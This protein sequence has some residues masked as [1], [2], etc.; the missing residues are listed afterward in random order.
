MDFDSWGRNFF[1]IQ[2]YF[3]C[4]FNIRA[5]LIFHVFPWKNNIK[6]NAQKKEKE[7]WFTFKDF[8]IKIEISQK[9]ILEYNFK[10]LKISL[11]SKNNLKWRRLLQQ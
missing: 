1:D 7:S 11:I 3:S 4:C 9:N 2:K 8:M 10:D 6:I 5:Y